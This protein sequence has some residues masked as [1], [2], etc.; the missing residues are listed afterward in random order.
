MPVKYKAKKRSRGFPGTPYR[1]GRTPKARP[2][3]PGVE[4]A[5]EETPEE[6]PIPVETPEERPIPVETPEERPI[7]V[8]TAKS[9]KLAISLSASG[10]SRGTN[11]S[12]TAGESQAPGSE[13]DSEPVKE[14]SG[15]R[16]V[17]CETLSQE[18]SEACVCSMCT[19]PLVVVEDLARRRGLVSTMKICCTNTECGKESKISDP[20]SSESTAL[21]TRSILAMREI[22]RGCRYMETF[23]GIM[24]ML[25]P[26]S[27]RSYMKHNQALATASM[28]AANNNMIAA[29]DYLHRLHSVEPSDV[30]DVRVTCDGT[31]SRR[32]FTA[33]HGVI[34]VISYDTGQVLDFQVMSKS[35]TACSQQKTRLGEEEFEVWLDGHKEKCLANHDGSSPAMECAGALLLWKR[36]VEA[37]HLRYTEV[38]SDGDSKTIVHLNEEQPYGNGV[39]IVKHE[40]VGHVQKRL[41]K[42]VR[43][44][45][46][47]IASSSQGPKEIIKLLTADL[48]E[49]RKLLRGAK[50]E[51]KKAVV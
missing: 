8:E 33:I 13:S 15:Y 37:R 32:G 21:N 26:L 10:P 18:V 16:I 27:P 25:P 46:K 11:T 49:V 41:G 20:L 43:A 30:L 50:A 24:N 3:S 35:C 45:K 19:A 4:Q 29:S 23:F 39:E 51:V 17:D 42:R 44:V 5:T 47:E 6:R 34:V 1:L 22:G 2:H 31:W 14:M 38:I 36:S 12:Q 48:K 9:K 40:C 28:S 7:P